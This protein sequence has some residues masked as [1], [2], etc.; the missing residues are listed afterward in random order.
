MPLFEIIGEFIGELIIEPVL[1]GI[2]VIPGAFFRFLI[3]R[4]WFSKKSLREFIKDDK[5]INGFIGLLVVIGIGLII[6]NT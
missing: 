3:S 2:L 4:I 5:V 6:A 1:Y